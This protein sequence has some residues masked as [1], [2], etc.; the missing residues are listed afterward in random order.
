MIFYS[1]K[2]FKGG[3]QRLRLCYAEH[4]K[5]STTPASVVSL[6]CAQSL[7]SCPTLCNPMDCS[8]PGSSV[9]EILQ[10][11]ILEGVAIPSSRGSPQPR[12]WIHVSRR[13]HWQVGSLPL[14]PPGKLGRFSIW[15]QLLKAPSLSEVLVMKA[16]RLLQNSCCFPLRW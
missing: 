15:S 16:V 9:H 5:G 1:E 14:A 13:Q 11:R 6:S 3:F 10:A 7:Q 12:E 2:N 4:K 8:P